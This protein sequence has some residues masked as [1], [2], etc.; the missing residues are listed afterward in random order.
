MAV[1][2]GARLRTGALPATRTAP[3]RT[4][5]ARKP[6]P[7]AL[8]AA[9]R[10]RPMGLLMAAIVIATMLALAYLTQ[11]LG[12]NAAS[13]EVRDLQAKQAQM[14]DEI[15][16]QASHVQIKADAVTVQKEAQR[17]ELKK[18][19]KAVTLDAP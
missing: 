8:S 7:A 2:Q 4:A 11:T 16:R 17:L 14:K 19:P 9:P 12:S 1:L 18:L 13:T 10:V 3:A 15:R 6:S 5:P